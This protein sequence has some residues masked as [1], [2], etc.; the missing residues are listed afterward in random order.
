MCIKTNIAGVFDS[1]LTEDVRMHHEK[2]DC[3][4][5]ANVLTH[6]YVASGRL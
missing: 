5:R 2:Q 3:E 6:L 1:I 4:V